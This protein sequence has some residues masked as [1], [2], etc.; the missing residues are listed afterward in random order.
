MLG[1]RRVQS[2]TKIVAA[3]CRKEELSILLGTSR[4]SFVNEA[5]LLYIIAFEEK[6]GHVWNKRPKNLNMKNL[7]SHCRLNY[8][9]SH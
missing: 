3:P 6:F 4:V 1:M 9:P 7:T 5:W 2:R 8:L